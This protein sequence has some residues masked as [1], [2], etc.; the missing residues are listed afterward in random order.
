MGKTSESSE[1]RHPADGGRAGGEWKKEG[2]AITAVTLNQSLCARRGAAEGR[3]AQLV[4]KINACCFT[5]R[6]GNVSE[7]KEGGHGRRCRVTGLRHGRSLFPGVY[8]NI[9]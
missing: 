8:L 3:R 4:G 7:R 6:E 9:I 5:N 2:T 1:T